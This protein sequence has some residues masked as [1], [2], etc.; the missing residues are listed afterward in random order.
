MVCPQQVNATLDAQKDHRTHW[1]TDAW[2]LRRIWVDWWRD[3]RSRFRDWLKA[4]GWNVERGRYYGGT[5]WPGGPKPRTCSYCGGVNPDD[6]VELIRNGWEVEPTTKGY[7]R[8]LHPPGYAAG[9]RAMSQSFQIRGDGRQAVEDEVFRT[10]VRSPVPPVKVY[11]YHFDQAQIEA[12][13][14]AIADQG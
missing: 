1:R 10:A 11:T 5:F 8:Y 9:L 2:S 6:A 12:F 3:A 14:A 7:K 4:R 13:N